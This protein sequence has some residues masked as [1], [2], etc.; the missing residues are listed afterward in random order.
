MSP[1]V[2]IIYSS[3]LPFYL[4][5]TIYESLHNPNPHTETHTITVISIMTMSTEIHTVMDPPKLDA[6]LAT[7]TKEI[8]YASIRL[9][10]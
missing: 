1:A 8:G 7:P 2:A 5:L 10:L 6:K 9:A 3:I 4:Y